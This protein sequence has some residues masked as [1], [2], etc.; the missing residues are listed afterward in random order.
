MI[1]KE[2]INYISNQDYRY[3]I[4]VEITGI[5]IEIIPLSIFVPTV[6]KILKNKKQKPLK[7]LASIQLTELI[8][9]NL[10][11]ILEIFGITDYLN[12][13]FKRI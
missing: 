6:L 7:L 3:G 9:T 2:L 5:V 10:D 1:L 8:N 4:Y 13:Q 12:Y 11:Q